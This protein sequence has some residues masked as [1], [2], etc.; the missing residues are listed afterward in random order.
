MRRTMVVPFLGSL[1]L[2]VLVTPLTAD[3]S[4]AKDIVLKEALILPPVGQYGRLP[5]HVDRLEAE[6]VLGKW[7]PPQVGDL[8]ERPGG[9]K[10]TWE[11]A[12]A[13]KDG[14]LGHKALFGGYLYWTVSVQAP[15]V[16]VLQARG[17]AMVY[18][19]GQ[20]RAGDIYSHGYVRLPVHLNKGVNH[21]LFHVGRGKMQ[22]RLAPAKSAAFFNTADMTL[23]D[24]RVGEDRDL[25]GSI[26]VANAGQQTLNDGFVE[27]QAGDD[28]PRRTPIPSLPPLSARPAA[29]FWKS[30]AQEKEGKL[31]ITLRLVK[32]QKEGWRALDATK[33]TLRVAG[34]EQ[35]YK[36]T[37]ISHIDGSVQYY[38]VR[39]AIPVR[40]QPL[41]R[42]EQPPALVLTLHGAGVDAFGQVGAYAS[43]S[44]AHIVAPTNRRPFGFDWEDWGRLDTLEVLHQVQRELRPDPQRVYLTGHSMGGHG[45]W[46]LGATYPDKFAAIGPSAGWITFWTYGA[47]KRFE[48]ST[49]ILD[50]LH[51]ANNSSDTFGLSRNY[52]HHGIYVLH[53]EAD[54]N[55]PVVQARVM[56]QH[57][58]PFHRDLAYHEE[59]KAG[60][61]W[62][63]PTQGC[64]DW[65]AL[66]DFFARRVR[67]RPESLRHVEFVTAN[68]AVSS[69][70]HWLA[71][72][73]QIRQLKFSSVKMRCDPGDRRFSGATD[74]VARLI[75]DLSHLPPG[76][77]IQVELDGQ[78]L[79]DIPWPEKNQGDLTLPVLRL[80]R[81][82][83][84]WS[85]S[86]R[87]NLEHKGSHRYGPFR[88]VFREN[89]LFVHGTRGTAEE[90]AW[91]LAKARF[92]A[93]TFWYR[94][95]GAVEVIPDVTFDAG[96]N[97]HRNVI[98]YGNADTNAAWPILL[99]D[100]PVQ[101]RRGAV[102]IG[103]RKET[104]D[105]LA[106][107]FL[108]P[109]PGSPTAS[110]GAIAGTGP[111]GMRLTD[112][113]PLFLSGVGL[114]DCIVLGPEMLRQG[115]AGVRAAGYFGLDWGVAGGE[116]AW[117]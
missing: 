91:A 43:K 16:W 19:N 113:V 73:A 95:N 28:E 78:T 65:P 102:V 35:P 40:G 59:P 114:P 90:N 58:S 61:W 30:P 69:W 80:Q 52:L 57:L 15:G 53:G 18:V 46:H 68:P 1:V 115:S 12:E 17:H 81:E 51:R 2:V 6:I 34:S 10:G 62:G 97:P 75:L 72:D 105:D 88:E 26:V 56:K 36:R 103:E 3:E 48:P 74:N 23:P 24:L 54:D 93:E 109:R 4:P 8:V 63:G 11:K 55:V 27:A 84:V 13:N 83:K 39:P 41:L 49:P 32:K 22:A 101:V 31:E 29:F 98:L 86:P 47:G 79:K 108:R 7:K 50:L 67:P 77:P 14:E 42:R 99:K 110:V 60:H 5:F 96:K 85:V 20:P 100:S 76:K 106:C 33:L 111:A 70:C 38:A 66:F 64:V 9:G 37:F 25:C 104:G 107:L 117:R 21:L 92:D 71:I 116:F 87:R 82:G 112:R 89:M 45:V 44:W 94:A